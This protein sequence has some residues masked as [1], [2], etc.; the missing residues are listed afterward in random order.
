MQKQPFAF[1]LLLMVSQKLAVRKDNAQ[2]L[3]IMQTKWNDPAKIPDGFI[4]YSDHKTN[5]FLLHANGL[6]SFM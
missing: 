3:L 5:N 1:T 2:W 4:R 6:F